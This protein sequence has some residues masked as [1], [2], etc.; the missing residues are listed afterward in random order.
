MWAQPRECGHKRG[1][2]EGVTLAG[3]AGQ[4]APGLL[5]TCEGGTP[6]GRRVR[7]R[8][9]DEHHHP[10]A[11]RPPAPHVPPRGSGTPRKPAAGVPLGGWRVRG[12]DATNCIH[13]RV[14]RQGRTC[15][16][17]RALA[18][19]E[20]LA[21]WASSSWGQATVGSPQ[22]RLRPRALYPCG[23]QAGW[24]HLGNTRSRAREKGVLYL[25]ARPRARRLTLSLGGAG[26][27]SVP[28]L[29]SRTAGSAH[30]SPR[31][32]KRARRPAVLGAKRSNRTMMT[33][34]E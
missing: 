9:D 1:A 31:E 32:R 33:T 8:D 29:R 4:E 26:A 2:I 12:L 19:A 24:K 28:L 7:G 30:C 5:E 23:S 34:E 20:A 17:R 3:A 25:L 18:H 10:R 14:R 11:H 15:S 22:P 13:S 27:K 21:R 16:Q 6:R